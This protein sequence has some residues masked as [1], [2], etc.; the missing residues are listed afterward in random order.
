M[1]IKFTDFLDIFEF[2]NNRT[3]I[4]SY[5]KMRG[6]IS[7]RSNKSIDLEESHYAKQILKKWG[8]KCPQNP[9]LIVAAAISKS[10]QKDDNGNI[11]TVTIAHDITLYVKNDYV[12]GGITYIT[13]NFSYEKIVKYSK[14]DKFLESCLADDYEE[15][16]DLSGLKKKV[17]ILNKVMK[18]MKFLSTELNDQ[19]S[20]KYCKVQ[21]IIQLSKKISRQ[22]KTKFEGDRYGD[23][24]TEFEHNTIVDWFKENSGYTL[25]KEFSYSID[26]SSRGISG[27]RASR[28]SFNEEY[29]ENQYY[30]VLSFKPI[31]YHTAIRDYAKKTKKNREEWYSRL[32]YSRFIK[33][34]Q[35]VINS[36]KDLEEVLTDKLG[37]RNFSI[38]NIASEEGL[39]VNLELERLSMRQVT[40]LK[41]FLEEV[42]FED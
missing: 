21:E 37:E 22:K 29:N 40:L 35:D 14:K 10:N 27:I 16:V 23:K 4:Y 25:P 39:K 1:E 13:E 9:N 34:L 33:G 24:A 19:D 7:K 18:E 38:R 11:S 36:V 26:K 15:M 30:P 3:D 20:S 42:E 2:R 6:G 41:N 17:T 28:A 12:S 32:E 8:I 5:Y 31:L